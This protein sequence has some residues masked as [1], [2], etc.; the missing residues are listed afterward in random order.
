M[1]EFEFE[2]PAKRNRGPKQE[3]VKIEE[4]LPVQQ[5]ETY[6]KEDPKEEAKPK[7]D[8]DEL[9]RIFDE[10]IFNG[11]YAEDVAIKGK[12]HVQFRTRSSEEIAEISRII[13][14]TTFN[15]VATMNEAKMVLNLQ[16]AL[17]SY[18]GKPLVGMSKEDKARF[19]KRL[20]GPIIGVLLDAL[21][22]FDDKVFEAC[23]ELEENF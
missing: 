17:T 15:L 16:Y 20:P 12:L 11:E 18:Q 7:Y 5:N 22:K 13:D 8:K 19:I 21:Y 6:E 1:S 9:L 3:E 23:K 4:Q 10:I 2:K 14:T